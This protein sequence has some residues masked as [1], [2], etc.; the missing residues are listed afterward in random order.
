[1]LFAVKTV[2]DYFAFVRSYSAVLSRHDVCIAVFAEFSLQRT[3]D[4]YLVFHGDF[5]CDSNI[6][7]CQHGAFAENIFCL[8]KQVDNPFLSDFFKLF[9][10]F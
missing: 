3:W 7:V 2:I 9:L 8:L 1:M 6:S 5:S 4:F 10:F